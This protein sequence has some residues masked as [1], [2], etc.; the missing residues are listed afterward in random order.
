MYWIVRAKWDGKYDQTDRFIKE[1]IWQNED[2]NKFIEEINS[3]KEN[4][5]LLL[6][7]GS[8]VEYYAI[9]A[10]NNNDGKNILVES[11]IRF[12]EP[13]F[14]PAKGS[15]IKTI[16]MLKNKMYIQR[17]EHIVETGELIKSFNINSL[18]TTNFMSLPNKK[19]IFSKGINIFIGE[20]GSG[21]SQILKL[22]Y[23]VLDTNNTVAIEKEETDYE[24][25][26][27]FASSLTDIFKADKLGNLVN[28]SKKESSIDIE[29][30]AYDISFKFGT[31]AK[32]ET[33]KGS[34]PLPKTFVEKK[35][36]FIPVKEVLSFFEGFRIMY[37]KKYLNFDKCY[38]N[39]CKAL[40]EP[41]SK[42][43]NNNLNVIEKL[44][45]ILNGKIKI[46]DGKFYLT[47]NNNETFEISLVAEGLRK[48]GLLSYLL[49]N[50]ALDNNSILF[51]D[52]PEANMNPKLIKDMV[53]FLVMLANHG[54]QIFISTH[55]PYI[56]ET[57]NNHLKKNKIKNLNYDDKDIEN[58]EPLNPKEISAYLLENN[59]YISILN[60]QLGLL[61]DKFLES[62][63][64]INT[65]YDKMRD[66]EWDNK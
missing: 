19:L 11:W 2:D 63:N 46:I 18:K 16:S 57:F 12:N 61:D 20:N 56:I 51:W 25:Q 28:K 41:L 8:Y 14:I 10:T 6:A 49:S 59:S 54:M 3:I 60:K 43:S 45:D 50:E 29:L 24:K 52:E 39:L 27:A 42:Q 48:I 1:N 13:I 64:N 34:I 31:N 32:K 26:R 44:E 65:L 30:T 66:I 37:E 40:E 9:C 15:Y 21:K 17:I 38:Y 22:L 47:T 55:S 5:I 23:S 35:S 36:V 58:I 62:F 53:K 4:D 33:G 7:N